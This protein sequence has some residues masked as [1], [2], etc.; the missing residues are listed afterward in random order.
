[1]GE[2]GTLLRPLSVLVDDAHSQIID[3]CRHPER[4]E[5][6]QGGVNHYQH[7]QEALGVFHSEGSITPE[8]LASQVRDK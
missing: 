8:P 7:V 5:C 6:L 2:S 1:M 4:H 3:Q